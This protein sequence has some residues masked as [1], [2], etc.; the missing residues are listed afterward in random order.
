MPF[1]FRIYFW[2]E[3][4]KSCCFG[5]KSNT[6]H[7]TKYQA[8]NSTPSFLNFLPC[9]GFPVRTQSNNNLVYL[10]FIVVIF[11]KHYSKAKTRKTVIKIIIKST[12]LIFCVPHL[13][14][15]S[16]YSMCFDRFHHHYQFVICVLFL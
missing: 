8:T 10:R 11:M 1:P 12:H 7:L 5:T 16:I 6:C 3:K 9:Y 13:L 2:L 14:K 15:T 4:F